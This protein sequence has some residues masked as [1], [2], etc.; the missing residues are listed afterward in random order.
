MSKTK[1]WTKPAVE[2]TSVKL[3]KYFTVA[4]TD[5]GAAQHRS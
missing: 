1:F 4:N 3:A 2:V 5:E